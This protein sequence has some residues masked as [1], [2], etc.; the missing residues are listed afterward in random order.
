MIRAHIVLL[1]LFSVASTSARAVNPTVT[2][3]HASVKVRP[4]D[5]PTSNSTAHVYAAQNEF[6]AFQ[7]VI[8]GPATNVSVTLPTLVGPNQV[9]I[10]AEHVRVYRVG[11][12]DVVTPSNIE[13]STGR[14][15]DALIP[16]IDETANEKRNAFPLSVPA[17][18]NRVAWVEIFVPP[19]QT[20]G[21][22][23]G[24]VL[25]SGSD[26]EGISVPVRLVVWDFALPSTSSLATTFGMPPMTPCVA[27]YGSYDACGQDLG[28][29]RV[30][31]MYAR[32][33][34]DHRI[35]PE[36]VYYGPI[37]CTTVGCDW[38]HFDSIYG[39][40]FDGTDPGLRLKGARATSIR[41]TWQ[42][43]TFHFAE[44]ARH[45]RQR[46]W[47]DLT[48][49]YS[50]DEPPNGCTWEQISTRASMVRAA[51]PDMRILVT[52]N[53]READARDLARWIDILTPVV[54]HLEDKPGTALAG[55]QRATYDQFLQSGPR[56][57]LWW[58]QSCMSHS[59]APVSDAFSRTYFTGWPN[60]VADTTAVQNRAQGIMSW[61]FDVSGV[62]YYETVL[63]LP[64]AWTGVNDF[65]GNAEGTLL[66]PGRIS[67][68]GGQT[69]VP[70][71]SIRLKMIR[72]GM[73]D[74]EYLKIVADLGDHAFAESTARALF[75]HAYAADQPS[76]AVYAARA[77]LAHRIL[78]LKGGSLPSNRTPIAAIDAATTGLTVEVDGSGSHDPDGSIVSWM[79]TW[80]DGSHS[81]G[82]TSSHT[83]QSAGS[84][85]ITLH[86]VDNAGA[87]SHLKKVVTVSA[88][89]PPDSVVRLEDS[90]PAW[91]FTGAWSINS[92]APHSDGT[93]RTAL[94]A[95]ARATVRFSGT[96]IRWIGYRDDWAG[97]ANVYLDGA[98][99]ARVDLYANDYLK[100][101]VVYSIQGLPAGTHTLTVEV[102][103]DKGG[104]S[105][106]HAVWID[107]VDVIASTATPLSCGEWTRVDETAPAW[108][109]AGAW[110]T[111]AS[112]PHSG[113]TARTS[114]EAGARATLGFSGTGVRWIAYRD[115]WAGTAKVFVD[116]SFHAHVDTYVNDYLKGVV[117]HTVEGLS[118]GAHTLTI[119]A[120]GQKNAASLGA[121]VWV[122][123]ADVLCSPSGS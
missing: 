29:E 73:E 68:I 112:A 34:I 71:A 122:D 110:T 2:I 105:R 102:T 51:D 55:N 95:G 11:Y 88:Q 78:E 53:I 38:T 13:G 28:V 96:G 106:G 115:N 37:D 109:F 97:I 113:G 24:E 49:D 76:T 62:L 70:I 67:I 27:H 107:A 123:A 18:E 100:Q 103:G 16:D 14:W 8:H 21:T 3:A 86:I 81:S 44:W 59:C 43:S 84:Y 94:E 26:F 50:C 64:Q 19:G 36:F 120:T 90:D 22:Y 99:R 39:P 108:T 30:N 61:L 40:L 45:F 119:E 89:P 116:G 93:A 118:P 83:Y 79:W 17:Q 54:N 10:P 101:V 82:P 98:F 1:V 48:Y 85:P 42:R 35:T 111:N 114:A 92:S 63:H 91:T 25:V 56:K 72:E 117:M 41:Y 66:Y 33:M 74:Y 12:L 75:P 5:S 4:G 46:G 58:Y 104:V 7:I 87:G 32:F 31:R 80:G 69:D 20:P 23:E 6:E 9:R 65:D 60:L 77:A 15:P 57:L 47:F 121:A 52:T